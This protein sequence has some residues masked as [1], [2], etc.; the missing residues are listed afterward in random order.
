M[1]IFDNLGPIIEVA[2]RSNLSGVQSLCLLTGLM[3]TVLWCLIN[4]P[5]DMTDAFNLRLL[6]TVVGFELR[7]TVD[8]QRALEPM[9]RDQW[10]RRAFEMVEAIWLS[11]RDAP[12]L[13]QF[14]RGVRG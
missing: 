10:D 9:I 2:N 5:S 6:Q 14:L 7:L 4:L 8:D 11:S 1:E 12:Q 3:R 13:M